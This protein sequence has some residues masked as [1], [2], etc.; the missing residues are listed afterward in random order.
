M[1]GTTSRRTVLR[2]AAVAAAA[3]P[4]V[5]AQAARAAGPHYVQSAGGREPA[6]VRDL[7]AFIEERLTRYDIPG[8][9]VGVRYRGVDHVFGLGVTNI[10]DPAPVDA[11]TVFRIASTSKT[12]TGTAIM[13]L[14][15]HGR[16]DLDRRVRHYLPDFRVADER[17]SERVTVRQILDHSAGWLGDFFLDPGSDDAALA[18]YVEGM[19]R[20]PQLTPPGRVM[21]YNNAALSLAGR[22]IEAV[23]GTTYERAVHDLLLAPL[24][25]DTSA[26]TLD[27]LPGATV[28]VPHLPDATGA[29]VPVPAAFAIP[30]SINPA[31]GLIS[32]ARDQLR[33]ARFHLGDG[34]VP[35]GGRRLL[36]ER[37][38]RAMR[39]RPGPAGT[40]YVEIDGFGVTWMIRPTAEGPRVLQH[41]GDWDGQ[42]SG[43][44]IV[45][46]RD[47]ALTVLTNS[48]TGPL[49]TLDLFAD[50]WALDRFLG[51][52]NLPAVPRSLPARELAPYAGS[53]TA[54]QIGFQGEEAAITLDIAAG[55]GQLVVSSGGVEALRL[56]FYRR[57][58]VLVLYP[59]GSEQHIRATFGR[60]P[61][62]G[63]A[64]FRYGG[65]LY[66]R[67]PAT[68]AARSSAGLPRPG[69]LPYP[70]R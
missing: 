24:G 51:L 21:H 17:A 64:W 27:D 5:G 69:T 61:D 48:E 13:R 43:F 63:I 38:L 8:A 52:H 65:R 3:G 39:S 1:S 4:L 32:S 36:S 33:W 46:E 34:R 59:D 66:L 58:H 35:G 23:T 40:L 41:G 44:L 9:A 30:R 31:G 19:T 6:A 11:D 67:G 55:D 70:A 2:A 20:L 16:I 26:F 22:V 62:G 29:L 60:D 56:A 47:F 14:A 37:S 54:R 12:F 42:H 45:P 7:R 15:E 68:L 28:A 57:D 25:L 10:A 50:D 18:R 53:Y 49:L